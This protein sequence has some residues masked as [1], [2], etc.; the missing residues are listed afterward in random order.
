M[1]GLSQT[2]AIG[3]V[4]KS[5]WMTCENF[6][7]VLKHV[8]KN[9]RCSFENK[10]LLILDNHESHVSI[11]SIEYCRSNGIVLLTLPPHTSNKTQPLDRTVFGPF[12]QFY[13]QGADAWM[14][15]HPGLTLTIYDLPQLC[16]IAWDRATTPINI[17]SGFRCTGI[18]PFDRNIFTEQDYMSSTVTDR[19][20]NEDQIN[21]SAASSELSGITQSAALD[22]N[23]TEANLEPSTSGINVPNKRNFISPEVIRPYPK[24]PPKKENSRGRPKK[25]SIIATD[26]PEKDALLA[27]AAK[28]VR[29]SALVNVKRKV[30]SSSESEED[31]YLTED[32]SSDDIDIFGASDDEG[33]DLKALKKSDYAIIKVYRKKSSDVRHFIGLITDTFVNG[34]EVQFYKR[35]FPSYRFEETDERS[36]VPFDDV[37]IKLPEALKDTRPRFANMI[38]FNLDLQ[39]Y[40]LL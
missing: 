11:E 14:M 12:K 30:V 28:K 4:H 27:G 10:I 32:N 2:G 20:P 38:Y 5:G 35:H 1:Q 16:S 19:I 33:Y 25:K 7:H 22:A 17:K 31:D 3:L 23:I 29:K 8:V 26:T 9:A 36:F 37:A 24:A 18:S 15:G 13:N 39:S 21:P 34:Y 40:S 6:I